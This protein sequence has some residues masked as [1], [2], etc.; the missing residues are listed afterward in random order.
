MVSSR[1]SCGL[2]SRLM[3]GELRHLFIRFKN[4]LSFVHVL[5]PHILHP[6]PE[7]PSNQSPLSNNQNRFPLPSQRSRILTPCQTGRPNPQQW[8]PFTMA[9]PHN[10]RKPSNS[11]LNSHSST[12]SRPTILASCYMV[13]ARTTSLHGLH[14]STTGAGGTFSIP[15]PP[16]HSSPTTPFLSPTPP[17]KP[18]KS[19]TN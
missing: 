19:P 7:H 14:Y 2:Q 5:S 8:Q 18:S 1:G 4:I 10:S 15:R 6:L 16:S 13:N 9:K 17:P 3:L 11:S 12:S